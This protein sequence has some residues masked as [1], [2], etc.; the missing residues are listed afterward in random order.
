LQEDVVLDDG[1]QIDKGV[2]GQSDNEEGLNLQLEESDGETKEVSPNMEKLLL[3]DITF[4]SGM[5][6]A[7]QWFCQ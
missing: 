2:S 6:K 7:R 1:N 3:S 4:S 5:L